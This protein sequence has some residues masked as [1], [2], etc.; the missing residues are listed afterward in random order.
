MCLSEALVR[1]T[2][3]FCTK[4]S[5]C[6]LAPESHLQAM[7][8]ITWSL[9]SIPESRWL[10]FLCEGAVWGSHWLNFCGSPFVA[11]LFTRLK[12]SPLASKWEV[13]IFQPWNSRKQRP[14]FEDNVVNISLQ[15]G[16]ITYPFLSAG[17]LVHN[18]WWYKQVH[19]TELSCSL[20]TTSLNWERFSPVNTCQR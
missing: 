16:I 8:S 7:H 6:T 14:A 15:D 19:G 17:S 11:T 4:K 2:L 1:L 20:L 5:L 3:D 12:A 18:S 13:D 10:E 9:E